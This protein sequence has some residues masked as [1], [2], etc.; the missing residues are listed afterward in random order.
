MFEALGLK[1]KTHTH[2]HT[3]THTY[4]KQ[5]QDLH[6]KTLNT[7]TTRLSIVSQNSHMVSRRHSRA[8]QCQNHVAD[9]VWPRTAQSTNHETGQT[10]KQGYNCCPNCVLIEISARLLLL[11]RLDQTIL[12]QCNS[13][14]AYTTSIMS[15]HLN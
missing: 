8:Q 14:Q 2:T 15:L 11:W 10:N 13:N 6:R 5:A 12:Q 4:E 7:Q 3:H 9:R 1:T